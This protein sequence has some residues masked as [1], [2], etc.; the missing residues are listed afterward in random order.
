MRLLNART[1]KLRDFP[2]SADVP[3]YAILSHTWSSDEV[4]F[5]DFIVGD[6]KSRGGYGK[7]EGCCRQAIADGFDY[8]VS[9]HISGMSC[10]GADV[11]EVDRYVLY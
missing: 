7:I 8:V 3:P 5:Q 11:V 9:Y 1:H 2:K 6:P 10:P 4:E